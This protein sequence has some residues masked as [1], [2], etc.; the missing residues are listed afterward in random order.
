MIEDPSK[1]KVRVDECEE[2]NWLAMRY[3]D[4]EHEH[5]NE[6]LLALARSMLRPL[7]SQGNLTF[8]PTNQAH[9]FAKDKS[10][11]AGTDL[12]V[13]QIQPIR[14]IQY[15]RELIGTL[16]HKTY[17]IVCG[18][19]RW[20]A[21][22]LLNRREGR[23]LIPE[24]D[25]KVYVLTKE[26]YDND[27]TQFRLMMIAFQ[28]NDQRKQMHILDRAQR[29]RELEERYYEIVER[30]DAQRPGRRAV[31]SPTVNVPDLVLPP[32]KTNTPATTHPEGA[33][34][35]GAATDRN[36][37]DRHTTNG[38][39]RG[40][41]SFTNY[42]HRMT[43]RSKTAIRQE[44][45]IGRKLATILFDIDHRENLPLG[46]IRALVPLPGSA[47]VD[48]VN[49]LRK[50]GKKI[51][52]DQIRDAVRDHREK[53][54]LAAI[55]KGKAEPTALVP[56]DGAPVPKR[57]AEIKIACDHCEKCG[58]LSGDPAKCRPFA[59]MIIAMQVATQVCCDLALRV[60]LSNTTALEM[61]RQP[62]EGLAI[63]ADSLKQFLGD[64]DSFRE[65][66][67]LALMDPAEVETSTR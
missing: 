39:I 25:A 19:R 28:E 33:P 4:R 53:E 59:A 56:A 48:I 42:M 57:A 45:Q 38:K 13:G 31:S 17:G 61:L 67:P 35:A 62:A 18:N 50:N 27:E 46:A 65:F 7:D 29:M 16:T 8:D 3:N 32:E 12:S 24:L 63:A 5:E 51:T 34:A 15:P 10:K 20:K 54:E 1:T 2:V 6:Q 40:G 66:N 11:V 30:K 26:E 23:P 21:A 37:T 52:E 22:C 49:A 60:R 14:V 41:E 47:Q 64:P 58:V 9:A 55:Q 36:E 43:G 44:V